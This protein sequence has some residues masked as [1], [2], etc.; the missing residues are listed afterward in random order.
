MYLCGGVC[1]NEYKYSRIP[2]VLCVPGAGLTE[3]AELL[4]VSVGN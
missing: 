2:E 3:M 4:D 1:M